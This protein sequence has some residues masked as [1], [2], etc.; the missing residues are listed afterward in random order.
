MVPYTP[1]LPPGSAFSCSLR[2]CGALLYK[3]TTLTPLR[4]TAI[5]ARKGVW[6]Q[7]ATCAPR[8]GR[9][10][11]RENES[12]SRHRREESKKEGRE[13]GRWPQGARL[14]KL[15]T[16]LWAVLSADFEGQRP[17]QKSEEQR[18]RKWSRSDPVQRDRNARR[19]RTE[20]VFEVSCAIGG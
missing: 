9:R 2:G 7:K 1:A 3:T 14:R 8:V 6:A 13:E 17:R 4:S 19:C 18:K 12:K 11:F 10:H 5:S 20:L 15:S 16:Y